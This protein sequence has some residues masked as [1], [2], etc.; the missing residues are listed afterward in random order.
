V[1]EGVVE[2]GKQECQEI[3]RRNDKITLDYSCE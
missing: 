2:E 1:G 3:E